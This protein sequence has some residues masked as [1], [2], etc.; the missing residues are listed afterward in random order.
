MYDPKVKPKGGA[1]IQSLM[2]VKKAFWAKDRERCLGAIKRASALGKSLGPWLVNQQ[3]QCALIKDKAGR[4]SLSGLALAVQTLDANP[5]WTLNGP[6]V[7]TLRTQYVAAQLALVESQIK[8]ERSLAWRTLDRLQ[9]VRGWM[10]VDDRAQVYR[11]AG[12][13]AFIEQNLSA[14]QDFF[15]RSLAEKENSELR[16]RLESLRT[17][18][19]G[20]K[21]DATAP[22]PTVPNVSPGAA[23]AGGKAAVEEIGMSDDERAIYTRMVRAF[24]SQDYLSCIEDGVQLLQ[25]YPGSRRAS[26]AADRILEIYLSLVNRSEEKF[27]HIRDAAVK[28]MQKADA[29]R[30]SRWAAN[31]YARGNY[32][33]AL[34]M[35]E[36]AYAK[37]DGHPDATKALL[38]AGK[39]ALASGEYDDAKINLDKLLQ[40]HGGTPEATEAAFRLGLLSYRQK[41]YPESAAYLERLLALNN[42]KEFEYRALYWQ[43]RAQQRLQNPQADML[44]KVLI[45]KYPLTYYGLRARAETGG[46]TVQLQGQPLSLKVEMRLLEAERLAWERLLVLLKAGWYKE[47]EQELATLPEPLTDEERL[48]R[49]RVWAACLRYDN[50]IQ[51]VN[52]AL[53]NNPSLG[54]INVLKLVFPQEYASFVQKESKSNNLDSNWVLSL[55]RQESSFR[56]DVRSP[57]NAMG[58][59]QLLPATGQEVARDLR[60]KDFQSSESL[61]DPAINIKIGSNYL[62]R[63]IREFKGNVLLGLAAYNAGP[64]RLRRWLNSRPDLTNV[65]TANTSS[66]DVEVW[67]DELPWEETSHYVKAILRNWLIYRLLDGSKVALSEPIWVDAKSSAR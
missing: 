51:L 9:Q 48:L 52:R 3:V 65:I 39:S 60:I 42:S 29:S 54:Q 59:M 20:K 57:A 27:R 58:V 19:L 25:K 56:P 62:A 53:D 14:A 35:A 38:L 36:K 17:S 21:K 4:V 1:F 37:Y 26:E 30:L 55:I 40:Q 61:L 46:G 15:T 12:E 34:L 66:P 28:E 11:W 22:T 47:A 13:L 31:A 18:V 6:Y 23:V 45:E 5:K 41:K 67:I 7:D 8:K 33:D 16:A 49:A 24:D 44:V 32:T 63:M 64:T 10:N 2:E 50:A 43:W